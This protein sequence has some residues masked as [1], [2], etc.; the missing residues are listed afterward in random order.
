MSVALAPPKTADTGPGISGK[1]IGKK[2][3]RKPAKPKPPAAD[4]DEG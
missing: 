1:G 3:K 2:K 4:S